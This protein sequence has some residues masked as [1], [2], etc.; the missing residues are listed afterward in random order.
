[1]ESKETDLIGRQ[2]RTV[3]IRGLGCQ[4]VEGEGEMLVKGH[5]IR[6]SAKQKLQIEQVDIVQQIELAKLYRDRKEIGDCL[7]P[8][9]IGENIG[10]IYVKGRNWK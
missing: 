6:V 4:G 10:G 5:I 1:M 9:S 3:V 2:S 7:G 8:G